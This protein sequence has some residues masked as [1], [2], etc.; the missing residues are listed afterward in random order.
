MYKH[1]CSTA[2]SFA[3]DLGP[4]L[5]LTTE[6]KATLASHKV[7]GRALRELLR[8]TTV[9]G[10]PGEEIKQRAQRLSNEAEADPENHVAGDLAADAFDFLEHVGED[11]EGDLEHH[12]DEGDAWG[13]WLVR[14]H[15]QRLVNGG[16]TKDVVRWDADK[17]LVEYRR[18]EEHHDLSEC[19][20]H[21]SAHERAIYVSTHEVCNGLIPARPVLTHAADV[22]PL[23]VELSVG[24]AHDFRKT[25]Q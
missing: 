16:L 20:R 23:C 11:D 9:F 14:A 3:H 15:V 18:E 13:G 5:N 6:K 12:A 21:P 17:Q 19:G 25:I 8:D 2:R 7:Q 24:E 1:P 22:P 10:V 4:K